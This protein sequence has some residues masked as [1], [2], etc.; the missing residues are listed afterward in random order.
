MANRLA[1]GPLTVDWASFLCKPFQYGGIVAV[2][3]TPPHAIVVIFCVTS[4][5]AS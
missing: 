5:M 1:Y 4:Y 3:V 2:T